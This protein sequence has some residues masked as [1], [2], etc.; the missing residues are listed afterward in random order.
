MATYIIKLSNNTDN[1]VKFVQ[2]RTV[3][4]VDNFIKTL[5]ETHKTDKDCTIVKRTY[6]KFDCKIVHPDA[7]IVVYVRVY[8]CHTLI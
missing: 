4:E 6:T 1:E 8:K 7:D 5:V 3:N 2:K